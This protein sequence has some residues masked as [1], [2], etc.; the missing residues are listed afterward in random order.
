MEKNILIF[1]W[2][3][4]FIYAFIIFR[5]RGQR[6]MREKLASVAVEA[7]FISIKNNYPPTLRVC[8]VYNRMLLHNKGIFKVSRKMMYAIIDAAYSSVRKEISINKFTQNYIRGEKYY[9]EDGQDV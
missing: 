8:F 3:A 4:I 1:V 7:M 9:E 6:R 5:E 2:V